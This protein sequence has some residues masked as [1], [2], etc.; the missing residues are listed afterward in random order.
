MLSPQDPVQLYEFP[1]FVSPFPLLILD[2]A[3]HTR[4]DSLT[5]RMPQSDDFGDECVGA[6]FEPYTESMLSAVAGKALWIYNPT[7]T[8]DSVMSLKGA[9]S[10]SIVGGSNAGV[11]AINALDEHSIRI[12]NFENGPGA[13]INVELENAAEIFISGTANAGKLNIANAEVTLFDTS[14]SGT[15][16]FSGGVLN[17]K[18]V[19]NTGT[20]HLDGGDGDIEIICNTGQVIV[21]DEFAGTLTVPEGTDVT[22]PDASGIVAVQTTAESQCDGQWRTPIMYK[23]MVGSCFGDSVSLNKNTRLDVCK[24]LCTELGDGC[25]GFTWSWGKSVSGNVH[26]Q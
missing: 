8:A 2:F 9:V 19:V 5:I 20:I 11:I 16:T 13:E 7:A 6:L 18:K 1:Y 4:T 21:G 17:A 23:E 15:L 10:V 14:N 12:A 25:V 24:E 22:A 3:S 26:D